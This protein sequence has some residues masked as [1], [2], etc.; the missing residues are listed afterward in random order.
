MPSTPSTP[1][2]APAP[3]PPPPDERMPLSSVPDL[4]KFF[5][6]LIQDAICAEM[7]RGEEG[8]YYDEFEQLYWMYSG[9]DEVR[10]D[11]ERVWRPILDEV[12][13]YL[14]LRFAARGGGNVELRAELARVEADLLPRATQ[15]CLQ[16]QGPAGLAILRQ[17]HRSAPCARTVET[18]NC[19]AKLAKSTRYLGAVRRSVP[20]LGTQAYG[21]TCTR[22]LVECGGRRGGCEEAKAVRPILAFRGYGWGPER[23]GPKRG[24]R[25]DEEQARFGRGADMSEKQA[26]QAELK[27][28]M[29]GVAEYV[30]S[31]FEERLLYLETVN[32]DAPA[33]ELRQLRE[34]YLEVA[35]APERGERHRD[36]DSLVHLSNDPT[37]GSPSRIRSYLDQY[38]QNFAFPLYRFYLDQVRR[39]PLHVREHHL[40]HRAELGWINDVAIDRFDHGSLALS[41]EAAEEP[42][43]PTKKLMLSLSKLA[44]VAQLD[45]Q[46]LEGEEV[47]RALEVVDDNLDLVNTQ[48][49]LSTFFTYLL[50][51][52]EM[53]L[54]PTEQGEVVAGRLA[55]ALAD[56][57]ALSQQ[58]ASLCARV[59]GDESVSAEDLIDILSLKENNA[60]GFADFGGSKDAGGGGGA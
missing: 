11:F 42:S 56:R 18:A 46:T 30:F 26:V 8:V 37:H 53:R 12:Q 33:P 55:P 5:P 50:S 16:R 41:T 2:R 13:D 43:A 47:Q 22:D 25:V 36:F 39:S 4:T 6:P 3:S 32:G 38:R 54:P 59:L 40:T 34:R 28:Q 7:S 29:A 17:R 44:Q 20:K 45:R 14:D 19:V 57:T 49:N 31:A 15:V 10:E 24:A 60:G 1:S 27:T 52:T 21:T 35:A 58:V 23:A 9:W 48:Q 51:G